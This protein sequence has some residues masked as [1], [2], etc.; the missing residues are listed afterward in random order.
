MYNISIR[1]NMFQH[2]LLILNRKRKRQHIKFL[3]LKTFS[4]YVK[5]YGFILFYL[6]LFI[7]NKLHIWIDYL[8]KKGETK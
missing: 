2:F 8:R 4:L 5:K 6:K 7:I 1:K 3:L